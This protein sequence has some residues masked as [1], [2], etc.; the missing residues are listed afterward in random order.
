VKESSSKVLTNWTMA[1]WAA[2]ASASLIL[3][4]A[5]AW[6]GRY[7]LVKGKDVEVCDAYKKNFKSF[8]N[9]R[10]MACE[11]QYDPHIKGFESPHWQKLDI[12]K[13]LHLYKQAETYTAT[14]YLSEKD[15]KDMVESRGQFAMAHQGKTELYLARLDINGDGR[16]DNILAVRDLSCGPNPEA[17]KTKKMRLYFLND[18]LTDIDYGRQKDWD[19]IYNNATLV[20]YKGKPHIERYSPEDGWGNLFTKKGWF[21]VVQVSRRPVSKYFDRDVGDQ[22]VFL[23]GICEFEF[24]PSEANSNR[25]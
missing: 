20:L 21:Y 6:A 5:P 7:D 18:T 2:L 17:E 8:D 24:L 13:Y 9:S 12:K 3:V 23:N 14:G 15:I 11:R 22:K 19:G 1:T 25:N 16:M 4:G 10:P